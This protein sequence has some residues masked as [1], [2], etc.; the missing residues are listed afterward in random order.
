MTTSKVRRRDGVPSYS[1]TTFRKRATDGVLVIPVI[2]EGDRI[3]TQLSRISALGIQLDVVLADGGSEDGSTSQSLL[4]KA[5]VTTLLTMTSDGALSSQLRMGFDYALRT[6]ASWVVTM[7]GNGKDDVEGI[8]TIVDALR[9]GSSFV[10]GSRFVPGGRAE[11]TPWLRYVAIR[12]VHAP[13]S[14]V[15]ARTHLTDTTNGFRGH[16]A[17]LL[18]D[19]RVAPFRDVFIG[20]EL[21]AYL[22]IQAGKLDVPIREVPVTRRYPRGAETP[23]KIPGMRGNADLLRV[24]LRAASGAY[25]PTPSEQIE[26]SRRDWPPVDTGTD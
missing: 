23:T 21:L 5:G 11:N 26:A 18:M 17:R 1:A 13:V 12:S 14:S 20:Y 7:D 10:Q 16:S 3:R 4:E 24:L 6:K 25:G 8:H 9:T 22:P 15:A 19:P 2:N